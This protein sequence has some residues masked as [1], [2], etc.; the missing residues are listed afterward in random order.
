[1]PSEPITKSSRWSNSFYRKNPTNPTPKNIEEKNN[2]LLIQRYANQKTHGLNLDL[3]HFIAHYQEEIEQLESSNNS[4]NQAKNY[5]L[6]NYGYL[7]NVEKVTHFV[8]HDNVELRDELKDEL[9]KMSDCVFNAGKAQIS[10]NEKVN[11]NQNPNIT[12][13]RKYNMF[14]KQIL[15]NIIQHLTNIQYAGKTKRSY[16]IHEHFKEF[17]EN[18]YH[19]LNNAMAPNKITAQKTLKI[20]LIYIYEI[21][22]KKYHQYHLN[23]LNFT[24]KQSKTPPPISR[25]PP[26]EQKSENVE[27]DIQNNKNK[28]KLQ[29][30]FELQETMKSLETRMGHV[31]N[32]FNHISGDK[33]NTSIT[34]SR[35][36]T[37]EID[38]IRK[39]IY[40][41]VNGETGATMCKN[42]YK[43]FLLD[44]YQNVTKTNS[45]FGEVKLEAR[46]DLF[47]KS[48]RRTALKYNI[49]KDHKCF[50]YILD[51]KDKLVKIKKRQKYEVFQNIFFSNVVR[52]GAKKKVYKKKKKKSIKKKYIKKK[53][54]KKK[55]SKKKKK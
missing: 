32:E 15:G 49:D 34:K 52:G 22:K 47:Y 14:F 43:Y 31:I 25:N 19:G 51:K 11:M 18:Y 13:V 41:P 4:Y 3:S 7:E 26:V 23:V 45:Y 37:D 8:I 21:I 46:I 28:N 10:T 33:I 12:C 2:K 17:L 35:E 27:N 53:S 30:M 24:L 20:F 40:D 5:G 6:H 1:M 36:M 39:K 9:G 29:K 48:I 55:V 38:K 54:I 16:S 44:Y 50:E 42:I